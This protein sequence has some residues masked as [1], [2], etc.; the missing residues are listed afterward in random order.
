MT[1]CNSRRSDS[2]HGMLGIDCAVVGGVFFSSSPLVVLVVVFRGRPKICRLR[3]STETPIMISSAL[4]CSS[5]I[6]YSF[7][8]SNSYE[9]ERLFF[10]PLVDVRRLSCV[11]F[12]SELPTPLGLS[13][14][15]LLVLEEEEDEPEEETD[16]A[17]ASTGVSMFFFCS[18]LSSDKGLF[19]GG[20]LLPGCCCCEESSVVHR[21]HRA[22]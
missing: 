18:K 12:F 5:S 2:G 6:W 13:S 22:S 19:A 21:V 9:T 10:V 3:A 15:L 8:G 16:S 4:V 7:S 1:H 17:S 20:F 11:V 14:V